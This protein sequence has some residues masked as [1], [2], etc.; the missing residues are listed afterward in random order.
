[1]LV[2]QIYIPEE[3]IG[4]TSKKDTSITSFILKSDS[5]IFVLFW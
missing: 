2:D 1:M 4:R 5:L 3:N